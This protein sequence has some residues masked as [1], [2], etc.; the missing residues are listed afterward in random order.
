MSSRLDQHTNEIIEMY[1]SG[2]SMNKIAEKYLVNSGTIWYLL[3]F[4]GIETRRIK[5]FEGKTEDYKDEIIQMCKDGLSGYAISKKLGISK[6]C[7]LRF[8]KKRGIE[9]AH[10]C[11]VDPNNLL[12]DKQDFVVKLFNEGLSQEEIGKITGHSGS[13]ICILLQKLGLE[14]EWKYHVNESFFDV[15]DTPEK[16][17]VL[18]WFYSDGC[19][20]NTGRLRI[21]IQKEDEEILTKIA[22][23]MEYEGPLYQVPPPKRFPHRKAQVCLDISRKVI[24][25]DLIRHGCV[26]NKSLVITYPTWIDP[27]LEPHFL[28]GVFDGDGSVQVIKNHCKTSFTTTDTFNLELQ[29]RLLSMGID[30]QLYYRYKDTNTCSLQTTKTAHSIALLDYLY[31]NATIYLDRKFQVYKTAKNTS[32]CV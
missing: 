26:P 11:S 6:P 27:K 22:I 21:Q 8:I 32:S 5:N 28:R 4:N 19:V 12:K 31:N 9:T 16:A 25:D 14:R 23:L 18:G 15:I 10:K 29:K 2:I 17:Y 1:Q 3:K 24:A 30:S 7:V 13:S 20:D